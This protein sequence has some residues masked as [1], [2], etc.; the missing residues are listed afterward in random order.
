MDRPLYRKES[1]D[2][3]NGCRVKQQY[4]VA[5]DINT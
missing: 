5:F 2:T 4:Q 1:T 3:Q